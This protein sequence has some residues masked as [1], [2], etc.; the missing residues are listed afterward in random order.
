VEQW[1]SLQ[2]I[3]EDARITDA[4]SGESRLRTW[5]EQAL[6]LGLKGLA[7]FCKTL[8]Y[9]LGKGSNYFVSRSSNGRTGNVRTN[10]SG[11]IRHRP[12]NRVRP[13]SVACL[14]NPTEFLHAFANLCDLA[15]RYPSRSN[16]YATVKTPPDTL[17]CRFGTGQQ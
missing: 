9:W 2:A 1:E 11:V 14:R 12:P 16:R 4:A 6:G 10:S 17:P 7:T 15:R 3:F 13:L 5:M 8:A